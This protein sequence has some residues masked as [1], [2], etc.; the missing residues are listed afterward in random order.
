M[1]ALIDT[2]VILDVLL[3]RRPWSGEGEDIFIAA[4]N[5][6]F[7]G[8]I[9]AKEAADVY[10]FARRLLAGEDDPE[11][12][13]R[14]I[15][16]GLYT[17]FELLDTCAVDPLNALTIDNSDYED[18]IMIETAKRSGVDCIVTRNGVHFAGS[19]VPVLTPAEFL[20]RYVY[21]EES[22]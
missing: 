1:R 22:R 21:S 13:A 4:A 12:S 9:T 11:R 8:C 17:I 3:E 19:P 15:M 7:T 6:M 2:N 5:E 10:Y 16:E 20:E 14:K 18:A